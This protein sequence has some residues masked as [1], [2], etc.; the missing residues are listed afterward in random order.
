MQANKIGLRGRIHARVNVPLHTVLSNSGKEMLS[1]VLCINNMGDWLRSEWDYT[2]NAKRY[3][4]G[5]ELP[6]HFSF[7]PKK[8]L[9]FDR[10]FSQ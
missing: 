5:K 2:R 7:T 6:K 4:Y 9:Y 10:T 1:V 3:D 8:G